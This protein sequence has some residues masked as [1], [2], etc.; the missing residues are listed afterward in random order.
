MSDKELI[1]TPAF[2]LYPHEFLGGTGDFTAEETGIYIKLLC[3]QWI[4]GGLDPER[5]RYLAG[6]Y[7]HESSIESVLKK[8]DTCKDG[9]LRN[10]RLE[11]VRAGV[12]RYRLKQKELANR[13]WDKSMP[14]HM[15]RHVP[16]DMPENMPRHMPN[17]CSSSSSSEDIDILRGCP[18]IPPM[19]RKD[20]DQ[21]CDMR[22]IPKDCAEHFWNKYDA[23]GWIHAGQPIRKIEPL[24]IN[25]AT[26]WRANQQKNATNRTTNSQSTDRNKGTHNEGRAHLYANAYAN[27]PKK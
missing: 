17:A 5:I 19:S 8:F 23:V 7:E 13:R 27:H 20:F 10:A 4:K 6:H 18:E 24:L 26:T 1:K 2:Q 25:A 22:A 16:G 21:L 3:Y 9:L 11:K 12:E 15:P 14:R